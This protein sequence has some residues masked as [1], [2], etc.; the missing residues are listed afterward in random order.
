[1]PSPGMDRLYI[2]YQQLTKTHLQCALYT[3]KK[4]SLRPQWVHPALFL[5][6]AQQPDQSLAVRIEADINN[7]NC[8]EEGS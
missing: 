1:M 4:R 7:L 2:L 8:L 6:S 5:P 3:G